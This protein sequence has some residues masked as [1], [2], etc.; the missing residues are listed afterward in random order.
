MEEPLPPPR[1]PAPFARINFEAD[2]AKE[3]AREEKTL[4]RIEDHLLKMFR[5]ENKMPVAQL[6]ATNA[7]GS[8]ARPIA[9]RLRLLPTFF[10]IDHLS[11]GLPYS[12]DNVRFLQVCDARDKRPQPYHTR[13]TPS[14]I[15]LLTTSHR[16][17]PCLC[18]RCSSRVGCRGIT[19][20]R[21]RV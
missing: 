17:V 8:T 20:V 16:L 12:S 11:V 9:F 6:M 5:Q 2:D 14:P 13:Y 7:D 10:T 1:P 3:D 4:E 19:S 15:A 21:C 18:N